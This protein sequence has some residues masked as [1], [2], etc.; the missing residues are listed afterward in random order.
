MVL[1]FGCNYM[2]YSPYIYQS[3]HFPVIL[4]L[5]MPSSCSISRC[6]SYVFE[7]TMPSE[8]QTISMADH[9]AYSEN[10]TAVSGPAPTVSQHYT[11]ADITTI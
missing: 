5:D 9:Y 11:D 6:H 2:Y 4:R 3:D 1:N 8:L 10:V 7:Q